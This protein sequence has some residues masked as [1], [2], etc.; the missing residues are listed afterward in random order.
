MTTAE[1]EKWVESRCQPYT[2]ANYCVVAINEEAGEIAGWWKKHQLRG[3]PTGSL[4]VND[5]KGELGDVLFYITR[6]A[7]H[8]GWTLD[9]IMNAN[10]AKI[11][12]RVERGVKI[13]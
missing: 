12:D 5:L 1:Y 2:D 3:N 13:A 10:R 8:Y 11:D 6:L 9:E 7:S 4:T